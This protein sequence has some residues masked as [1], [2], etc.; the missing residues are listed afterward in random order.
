MPKK[1]EPDAGQITPSFEEKLASL[2]ALVEELESPEAP[3]ERALELFEKGMALSEECRKTLAEAELKVEM[4]L[5]KG[6]R[7][8]AVPFETGDEQ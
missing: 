7:V 4:L 1:P 6:G 8:E 5:E 2:E 3:L